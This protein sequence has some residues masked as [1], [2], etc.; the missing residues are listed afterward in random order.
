MKNKLNPAEVVPCYFIDPMNPRPV[1]GGTSG[2]SKCL[3]VCSHNILL[4]I[5]RVYLVLDVFISGSI[6]VI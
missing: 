3:Q 4:T 2:S 1:V 6:P 5:T